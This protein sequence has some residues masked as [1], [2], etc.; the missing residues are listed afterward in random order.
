MRAILFAGSFA[1]ETGLRDV[2]V[3]ARGVAWPDAPEAPDLLLRAFSTLIL[4]GYGAGTPMSEQTVAAL[5]HGEFS[6]ARDLG[7]LV[8]GA[9][10]ALTLWDAGAWD[11]LTQRQLRLA[12]DTGQLDILP[13][14]LTNRAITHILAGELAAAAS[15]VKEI[16]MV[17]EATGIPTPPYAA[18]A[19]AVFG[20][21]ADAFRLIDATL[22][23][24]TERGE[25]GAVKWIQLERAI[26]CNASGR[27]D[28]ALTAAASVYEEPVIYSVWIGTELIE[29][30]VR[31]GRPER[32]ARALENLREMASAAG[33]DWVLG[34]EARCRALLGDGETA[35]DLYRASIGHLERTRQ[36]VD[37]ARSHLV[38]GEWLRR[39]DRRSDA[40]EQLRSARDMFDAIGAVAFSDRAARELAAAG[41]TFRKRPGDKGLGSD[42]TAREAQIARL[43]AEGLSNREI[44]EQLFISHRTVGYHLGAVFAK[45][46]V[47]SRAQLHNALDRAR[48]S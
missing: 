29:S 32:A 35:E 30:A 48:S 9:Q 46:D 47:T 10:L 36:P 38:Y 45:L 26:L 2:A 41:E 7:W 34:V 1:K 19:T 24:A 11:E 13:I 44:G 22:Q 37:L 43:A 28:D 3:A 18:V 17:S 15:L 5:R 39:E 20:S 23:A 12:R 14:A 21:P 31:S 6:T 8:L 4:D 25:G 33:T 16:E 27:Y 40:R 42:L